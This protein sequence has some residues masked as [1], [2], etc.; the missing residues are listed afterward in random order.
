MVLLSGLVVLLEIAVRLIGFGTMP[1]EQAGFDP[2]PTPFGYFAVC[3][4]KLGFRNR[5]DGQYESDQFQGS[6]VV[7]TDSDG[8]RNGH[9]WTVESNDPIVLFLGDSFVFGSE[10]ADDETGPSEVAKRLGP[11]VRVLNAG[12][13]GYNTLQSK[14]MLQ[15]CLERFPQVKAAV[16]TFFVN[17]LCENLIPE[18]HSPA[19]APVVVRGPS[20]GE[21]RE[22]EVTDPAVPFGQGFVEEFRP[23]QSLGI[24]VRIT[25]WIRTRSALVHTCM[26]GLRRLADR[27]AHTFALPDGRQI[28]VPA[29]QRWDTAGSLYIWAEENGGW[30][31]LEHLLS[32]MAELCREK[33]V[34]FFATYATRGRNTDA[35]RE[36]EFAKACRQAG[37]EFVSLSE[38]FTG[39]PDSYAAVYV[40]GRYDDHYG[41][42]GTRAFAE[43]LAPVIRQALQGS[44][45]AE[46]SKQ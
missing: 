25:S 5:P 23:S 15:E 24:R 9:G 14:R 39:D 37:V 44:Q 10:V 6:P 4:E 17:D 32:E 45:P 34:A 43:G 26:N 21:F 33:E 2:K 8:F 1:A 38:Q 18:M 27:R 28:S 41:P 29:S 16:Y 40:D 7:T 36:A 22:I 11:G 31:V 19:K 12:S 46:A 3:D 30:E 13:R 20:A 35:A 42:R